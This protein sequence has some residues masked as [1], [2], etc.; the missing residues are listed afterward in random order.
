MRSLRGTGEKKEVLWVEEVDRGSGEKGRSRAEDRLPTGDP[1]DGERPLD[2]PYLVRV[3]PYL[4]GP[5]K[6]RISSEWLEKVL[7]DNIIYVN[8]PRISPLTEWSQCP[9]KTVVVK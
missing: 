7:H 8:S 4:Q 6:G 1:V 2:P 5:K 9:R 3:R